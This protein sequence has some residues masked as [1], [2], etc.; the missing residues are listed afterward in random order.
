VR[1]EVSPQITLDQ[2]EQGGHAGFVNGAFPGHL[3]WMPCHVLDYFDN[4]GQS[5]PD[6]PEKTD[7]TDVTRTC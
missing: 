1:S 5:R 6:Q 7:Q 4:T 3:D 2:P